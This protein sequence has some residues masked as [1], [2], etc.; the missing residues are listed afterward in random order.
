MA[1][2][3]IVNL[4][5]FSTFASAHFCIDVFGDISRSYERPT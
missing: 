3:V 5:V 2:S 1:N 4:C